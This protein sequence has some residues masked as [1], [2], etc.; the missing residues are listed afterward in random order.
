MANDRWMWDATA[1][2]EALGAAE[3]ALWVWEP[4][5]DRLRLTGATRAL[6]LGPLAPDCSSAA[7]RALALPQDRA[8]AED[9]LRQQQPGGEVAVRLRM[10]GGSP[11]IWRGVWLEEGVRAAGVIAPE[12][13][14]AA[15]GLDPLTGLA[16]RK[17][18]INLARERLQTPGQ[19]ELIVADLDRLR[20][21]NEALGH[22]RADLVLA[23]LGSRLAAAFPPGALLGRIGED[24]FAALAPVSASPGAETL[25]RALEQPL[26][27]AGFDIHPTLSIGAVEAPGGEEAPEAAELLRR[28]ELAVESAKS[29]GRGGAAA[30]GRSLETDGLSRLALEG[31]LK[32]A[33]RRGELSPFYQPIV[34][35]STGA[36]SGFEA[37]VRW[38]H[39]RRG[40]LMPEQ[41]LPLC[42]EMGL[43]PELGAMMMREASKQLATWRKRHRAAGDL[44]VAVNLSTGELER[45]DLIADVEQI[46]RDTGL[47]PGALK[48]EVTEGD[49]MRDPDKAAII[50]RSLR[51]AGA[52]LALDDF[53]TG[54]SSL[55]YL[56]RLPFDTLKVDRYFV[57]TMATNEGSAKIVSSVVKLG[58]DLD[59]EVVA[60]GVE[61]AGMARHLLSLGCDYGQG[62]G[63]APALSAQEAEVYL[64]ES[65]VDGAAPVKA[66]G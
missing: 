41:F 21:L 51:A 19:H 11:C 24:E 9:I 13:R 65:Y 38:R 33:L 57:R 48:L 61:N 44:T 3:V 31:D 22:E 66:R 27:V 26:R 23:A 36:L 55:S 25:R 5:K 59:M 12:V 20:R 50:L 40:L 28:A 60:E 32:G 52:A 37:L 10:R 53:G 54:F 42:E 43:M 4:E 14:F 63:Y 49:V 15:S 46:R 45:P 64:N 47:P 34:R 18:F 56:T 30:Y 8:I 1:T 58:Q 17:S 62:F 2:L 6:G 16:D 35:L 29:N 39:P 7:L